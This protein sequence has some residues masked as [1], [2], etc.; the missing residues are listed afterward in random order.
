MMTDRGDGAAWRT[1]FR[2]ILPA[3]LAGVALVCSVGAPGQPPALATP[4]NSQASVISRPGDVSGGRFDRGGSPAERARAGGPTSPNQSLAAVSY[5]DINAGLPGIDSGS[6]AWGDYDNDGDLDVLLTGRSGEGVG[7]PGTWVYRNDGGEVFTGIAAGLPEVLDSSVAWGDYDNDGDLD[8]L[9]TGLTSGGDNI[10]RV[11]RNDGMGA[12]AD[13]NAGLPGVRLSSVAWGDYDNDGDLDILLTGLAYGGGYTARVY[14]NDG[15]GAFADINA[16]LPGVCIGSVAWGDYDNDGDL[17]ILLTG[18][19]DGTGVS[20][21]GVYR[22]DGQGAFTDIGAGLRAVSYAS[23]AWGDYDSDGDLDI[24][25]T[26]S[27]VDAGLITH[28]YRND[29]EVFTNIDAGL[30][31]VAKG[32]TEWGDCD[33]DGDLDLL[34]TGRFEFGTVSCVYRNDGGG[35]FYPFGEE[36]PAVEGVDQGGS[37]AQWGDF[38]EDGDLDIVLSG[39]TFY[40]DR[41]ARIFRSMGAPPNTP[42]SVPVGLAVRSEGGQVTLSWTASTDAETPAAGLS[43]NLRVGTTPGGSEIMSPMADLVTGYRRVAQLG[44]TQERTSWELVLPGGTYYWTVQAIDGAY[45]GS[46]FAPEQSFH[47][48]ALSRTDAVLGGVNYGSLAWGDY[49]GDGD[50]DL[51]VAGTADNGVTGQTR[52]YRNDGSGVFSEVGAGLPGVYKGAVAG[53]DYDNDGD[54]DLALTGY[55][56]GGPLSAIYRNDGGTFLEIPAGLPGVYESAVAWS[57]YDNDGDLDLLLAG[58]TGASTYIT[59]LY[60]ND[61][62][63]VFSD[64][65][66][67]LTGVHVGAVAWGD[68]DADGD[69]DLVLTG[70]TGGTTYVSKLYRNDGGGAF[71]EVPAG[72]VGLEYSSAAWG[73]YDADGDLDILLSGYAS[74]APWYVTRIYRNDGNGAF[75]DIGAALPGVDGGTAAWGDYDDDG[76]L[77]V[78]LTG[79]TG[80]ERAAQVYRNDGGGTF[81]LGDDLGGGIRGPAAWADFDNDGDLDLALA[82]ETAT[83]NVTRLYRNA[84][85]PQNAPPEAPTGLTAQ[86]AGDRITLSWN[87][88]TDDHTPASAL[89]YNLRVGTTPGGNELLSGI[90]NAADGYRRVAQMGNVQQRTSWTGTPGPGPYYWSVQAVDGAYLGSVFAAEAVPAMASVVSIEAEVDRIRLTWYASGDAGLLATV[91]RRTQSSGWATLAQTSADGTG[92]LRYV[93]TAVE[94]GQRYGYRLGLLQGTSEVFTGEAWAEVPGEHLE[95]GLEAVRPNPSPNGELTVEFTLPS[96]EPAKLEVMDI[97]GRRVAEERLTTAGRHSIPVARSRRLMPGV[98]VVRLSQG[99]NSQTT[100]ATVVP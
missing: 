92:Y 26:G 85:A 70:R 64:V 24:V 45:A 31:G 88:S 30:V 78:L 36:F 97:R 16:G 74:S 66:A 76:D 50:L 18:Q 69:P 19:T 12:F 27:T 98:Y 72:L 34:L 17:D 40:L 81:V 47:V 79:Y 10:A 65:G 43:Y 39:K 51:L 56:S 73:D 41:L 23:A 83:G 67:G 53:G 11:Y 62:G 54:V 21:A 91:Y 5:F 25:L 13:I 1:L 15:M 32:S 38:D 94:A 77:D 86:V 14:R 55:G 35:T 59:R 95:F 3:V 71:T 90:A 2:A 9:L 100:R 29:A 22:N 75:T 46:A 33:N 89:T 4:A 44:N 99:T 84:G 42:P 6:V 93:D 52:L 80:F 8:I 28:V 63:G 57:D 61:G 58:R 37:L 48:I 49:D 82:G 68:Y 7:V 96:A 87:A 60:R 20:M